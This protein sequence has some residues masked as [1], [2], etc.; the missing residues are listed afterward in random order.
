MT[1]EFVNIKQ[2]YITCVLASLSAYMLSTIGCGSAQMF[3]S[4]L[5]TVLTAAGWAG[6]LDA[7]GYAAD[8]DLRLR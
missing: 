5:T 7:D 8:S 6:L 4:A 3:P 2:T 1:K